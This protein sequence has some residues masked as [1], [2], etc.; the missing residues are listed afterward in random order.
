VGA[1]ENE[2][3]ATL[4]GPATTDGWALADS[5]RTAKN[6]AVIMTSSTATTTIRMI[7]AGD[8]GLGAGRWG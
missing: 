3:I 7:A 2:G 1:W 5:H 6:P 8:D 4:L